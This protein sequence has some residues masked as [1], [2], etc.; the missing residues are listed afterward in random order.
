MSV[1]TFDPRFDPIAAQAGPLEWL[2]T[3][4]IWS[5]GPV[6]MAE[7]P[8]LLWSDIPNNRMMRWHADTGM[9]VWREAVEYTNGHIREQSG[10]LQALGDERVVS[11]D[12]GRRF[13]SPN[14]IVVKSDSTLW[15]TDPAPRFCRDR[16]RVV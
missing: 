2:C 15:F 4:C 10:G 11:H 6:W 14:D 12:Q 16:A 5:E 3:G 9:S 7:D 8:S 13:N 1:Q